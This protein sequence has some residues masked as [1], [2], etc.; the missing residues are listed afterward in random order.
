MTLILTVHWIKKKW[1]PLQPKCPK[2]VVVQAAAL[3]VPEV[4]V[5]LAA[6][7]AADEVVRAVPVALVAADVEAQVAEADLAAVLVEQAVKVDLLSDPS[8]ITTSKARSDFS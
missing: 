8:L 6:L 7:A 5:D 4:A 3:V 1:K 2:D